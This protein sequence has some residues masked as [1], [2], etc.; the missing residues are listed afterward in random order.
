VAAAR[1]P[2]RVV[3]PTTG[4]PLGTVPAAGADA[5][6]S[7]VA[8]G[9]RAQPLWSAVPVAARAGFLRR[10]AQAVLDELEALAGLLARETGRPRTEA[11]LAE[12][13][14]SVAG[15]H[16][17]ADAAPAVLGD[18]R[19]GR[20]TART[21]GR[22][23]ALLQAPAGVVGLRGGAASPWAEPLLEAAAALV[24]GNAVVLV[25]AARLAGDRIAG[26]LARAGVPEELMVVL[27]GIEAA[28]ALG[29]A[30]DAVGDLDPP[31]A[32]GTM[33]V[34]D[35]A[36]LGAVVSGALW[37]GFAGGGRHPAAVGQ[38]VTAPGL[39]RPLAD[40]LAAGTRQLRL[41]DPSDPTTEI[42]PLP[43][44]ERLAAVEAAVADAESEG[45]E[46]LCGGPVSIHGLGG[47]FYAPAVLHGVRPGSALLRDPPPGP[48]LAVVEAASASEAI[49]LADA[50][51]T[52]SVWAGDRERGERVARGLR[53]ELT[54]VNEHGHAA[55]AA[56][57]RL[58]R[59]VRVRQLAS[60]SSR[61]RSARWLPYDPALVRTRITVARVLFGRE[62]Q[63]LDALRA[64]A[65]PA[66]RTLVRLGRE[67]LESRRAG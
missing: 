38:I 47:V 30:C 1:E 6:R 11:L 25:P 57:V 67:A 39:G 64:G 53:A 55:A 29:G 59:H 34:L 22:H 18:Q 5:V 58:A 54:W 63:R 41:G 14:P 28:G 19:L 2:L 45:A 3:S 8:L 60:G 40:A 15:L 62:S 42:G 16:A 35:G 13:L 43:S 44:P 61:L 65:R 51:G 27:H 48:V 37:A 23:A 10:A 4:E 52:V 24:A 46:R 66:A 9:R 17:L 7:A 50:A 20:R 36:P 21:A 56:P 33:L 31:I 49:A 26:V 32:K 12:L